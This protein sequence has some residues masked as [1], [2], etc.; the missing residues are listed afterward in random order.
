[1]GRFPVKGLPEPVEVFELTGASMIHRRLQAV[2]ARGLTRFVGRQHELETL[3]QALEQAAAGHG[4]IVAVVGEAG[5][6]KSRLVYE[7]TQPDMSRTW[8]VLEGGSVSYGKATPYFPVLDLLRHYMHLE[9]R[10][11]ARTIRAKVTGHVLVTFQPQKKP[12]GRELTPEQKENNTL[13]SSIRIVIQE[14]M[15]DELE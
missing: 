9:E 10:D 11:E 13:I 1:L 6:G 2:A 15:L 4:Q 3:R 8:L 12:K 7:F 14:A 5:V